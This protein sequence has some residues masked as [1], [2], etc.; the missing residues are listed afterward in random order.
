M[1]CGYRSYRAI[2]EWGRNYGRGLVTALGFA[3]GKTPCASALHWIFRHLDCAQFETQLGQWTE[4]VVRAY[5]PTA[6]Q[7]EGITIDGKT[8]RG[9]Q[10]QGAPGAHL[11]SAFSQRLGI[12]LAQ[13]AHRART[14]RNRLWHHE[15]AAAARPCGPAT[16]F[17]P[18]APVR[19]EQI[20]LGARCDF[21]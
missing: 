16:Q 19:R 10:K 20:A 1:L 11:L 18:P 8:L 5:P 6:E 21:R 7:A 17:G 13:Q 9:S 14:P 12:T 4:T 3:H 2:A 15:S